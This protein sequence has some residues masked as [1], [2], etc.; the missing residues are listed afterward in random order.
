MARLPNVF[1][2][3][4][5]APFL[6]IL[7]EDVLSGFPVGDTSL[8]PGDWTILLPT[9]RAV[10]EFR[11][12][13]LKKSG[14]KA[15][16]L[17]RVA[18]LNDVDENRLEEES[19]T[20]DLPKPLSPVAVT[21]ALSDLA[22]KW[23][24]DNPAEDLAQEIAASAV[25]CLGL[26]QSLADF[27]TTVETQEGDLSQL[28]GVYETLE[29]A[30]HREAI[31]GLLNLIGKELPEIHKR[32]GTMGPAARRSRMLRL[33]AARIASGAHKG[34]I[35]AA[36]STGTIPA[37]AELLAAI[38]RHPQGALVLPGLDLAADEASWLA[39]KPE[40]PQYAMRQLLETLGIARKQV[41]VRGPEGS[42][43]NL[44]ASELMRPTETASQWHETLPR[45]TRPVT[46]AAQGLHEIAAADRHE[47]ARAIALIMREVL[48]TKD[49]R[50][51][52]VTPDRDL[53]TRVTHELQRWNIAIA[54][55]YGQPL[56]QSGQ[57][58][59]LDLMLQALR[60]D[61]APESMMAF[62]R[63]PAVA[64]DAQRLQQ[65][66]AAVLRGRL[67]GESGFAADVK[68]AQV[69]HAHNSHT[70]ALVARLRDEDWIA[71]HE[72]GRQIDRFA[73]LRHA[74]PQLFGE[75]LKQLVTAFKEIVAVTDEPLLDFLSD[76]QDESWRRSSVSMQEAALILRALLRTVTVRGS[77]PAHPRL[78]ILGTLEA[79]L[80]P[81]DVM[82]LGGLN[83]GVWP[84]QTDPGPWLNRAMRESL[85]LPQ[86]ER[87]IGLAAHDFEQGFSQPKVYLTW[88]KRLGNA[89]AIRS[90]WLLRLGAVLKVAGVTPDESEAHKFLGWA[91]ALQVPWG[92]EPPPYRKPKFAPPL[93]ARPRRFSATEVERLIRN[94]YAIYARKILR[95]E[96]LPDF[97]AAPDAALRG[98]IF[99]E[100]LGRW[101]KRQAPDE[102]SLISEGIAQFEAFGVDATLRSFWSP[103]FARVARWLANLEPGFK[104][105]LLKIHAELNGKM[106]FLVEGETYTLTARADRIDVLK[107]GTARIMDYKT[108]VLPTTDQVKVNFSPQMT[109]EAA[110]VEA[111]GFTDIGPVPAADALYLRIAKAK[112]GLEM[113]S[114]LEEG[115]SL[116]ELA[117]RHLASF[118]A[119]LALYANP[120]HPYVPRLRSERDEAEEEFDHLS[121]YLEWQ[122]GHE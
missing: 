19:V 6:E 105:G 22:L 61:F 9:R 58:L 83:E 75:Q 25:Q 27:V 90:R 49:K 106:E 102:A 109:L 110:I 103:H 113:R 46:D 33:E 121:R 12:I 115:A 10:S 30:Q 112:G 40:H 69:Q 85:G 36:G 95:L 52:L 101:N 60:D 78:S 28:A 54:D 31:I 56:S 92:D 116:T 84:A 114:V 8:L 3:N 15:L 89:P 107:S 98:T 21:L 16:L 34:P 99:H 18:P 57:G 24:K 77:A 104:E 42:T 47:E 97:V 71:L 72:L 79:R 118:K 4:A 120:A 86:P 70:H 119:M 94:P 13:L 111:G 64:L 63:H 59:A 41:Q 67:L 48:E 66:E 100:A 91:K 74:R 122:A 82:I 108:G 53:A 23:A 7:A 20:G 2:I 88:S 62:L 44:L 43:R 73:S 32:D 37:T 11:Q 39:L 117:S 96:P 87:D 26:A 45:L 1:T 68:Q 65:F 55:S 38:S 14:R 81:A 80:I 29:L 5:G 93:A 35:I 50:A 17:P 76:A 51:I